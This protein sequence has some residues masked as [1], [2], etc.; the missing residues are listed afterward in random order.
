MNEFKAELSKEES[1]RLLHE[2]VIPDS[3]LDALA[4]HEKPRAIVLAGQPGAGKGMLVG[5]ARREFNGDIL[6]IDPDELRDAIPGIRQLQEADPI[7]WPDATNRGA[8]NLASGLRDEGIKRHVNLVIDG[9]MSDAG[10]SARTIEALQKKGY[11]V[12][13]RAISSHWLES[14]LGIDQRFTGQ[15]DRIGVARD[16][17]MSFHND[18]YNGLPGNLDKVAERTGVQVRIYDRDLNELYDSRRDV[19][20][21]SEVLRE[22]RAGRVEEPEVRKQLQE[23]WKR[24]QGWHEAMPETLHARQDI[25]PTTAEALIVGSAERAK[26]ARATV[27]AESIVAIDAPAQAAEPLLPRLS[28]VGTTAGLAG[29]GLAAAAYD[30]KETGERVSTAYA[31]DNPSAVRSEATHFTA[32]GVGGAAA[33]FTPAAVGASGGPAAA[34]AVA[35]GYLLTEAFD[36]GAKFLDVRK[37]THQTASDGADYEFNG[38]QWIREDLRADFHDDGVQRLQQQDF[39]APPEIERELNAKASAEAVKQAIGTTN[40]RDPFEQPANPTDAPSTRPSPWRYEAQS[41]EWARAR[42]EEIDPTDPRLPDREVREVATAERAAELNRQALGVIDRNIVEGP[43]VLAAQYQIGAKRSGFGD[44][45][46]E[47]EAV[48]TALNPNTL[49]ASNGKQYVRDAQGQWSHDGTPATGNRAL[50]LDATR[51]RLTPVLAQHQQ[52]LADTKSYEAPTP[53]Q[54]DRAQLRLAYTNEGWNPS[55][56]QFKASYFGAAGGGVWKTTDAGH[57]WVSVFDAQAASVGAVAVAPSDPN[58]IYVGSGQPQPRYDTAAG[59]GVYASRDGGKH[60]AHVGLE[61]TRHIGA[62][63]IDPRD[64]NTL[65]VAALGPL[66][67]ESPERGVFRSTD[68]GQHWT[69]TL[70]IDDATGAVDLASDPARPQV[71]YAA[72]WTARN[73]PWMSYFTPMVGDAGGLFKSID[74]GVSWT[75]IEGGGWPQG[76]LGRVGIAATSFKGKTRLYAVVDH[77]EK[78]GLYRSDDGGATWQTMQASPSL[79][80]RYFAR[81]TVHPTDPDTVY[82]MGRSI[83]VSHDGG[84]TLTIMRGSPGGD[85]YHDLWLNPQHPERMIAASDQG[86]IVTPNGGDSWSDWYNQ[87]T[88]QFYCL[89]NDNRFP[90][91]LYAGQQ[92]NGS[93]SITSRSNFGAISFRDWTPAG[94][95]ERD[96]VVPDPDDANVLYGSGLG[97]RVSRY[98]ARTGD[99]QN[100]TPVQ[101]NTYGRDPRT[102]EH[103]WSWITPLTMAT[104][105]ATPGAAPA[106]YLGSEVLFR[107]DDRGASW[108]VISP[109]LT[110][111]TRD[112]DACK[113]DVAEA[114]ARACGFGTIFSIAPSPHDADE[115]W[116]GTDSGL[117][118]RTRDGGKTW[119]NL[120]P[121]QLPAWSTVARIELSALDREHVYVAVDQHRRDVFAPLLLRTRDGGETW[122]TISAGLPQD[123]FTAVIRA[124]HRRAGLLF[125][126][127]DHG[128]YVSLDDGDRW[129]PFKQGMPTAWVRDMRIVG[130][131]IAIATQGRGLWILDGIS[132]LRELAA[133]ANDSA[134]RLF[135]VADAL[136]LRKNQNKDTPLAAEIPLGENPPT[137][138]LIEYVLP[139]DAKRVALRIVDA[140]GTVVRRFASDDAMTPLPAEQYFSDLY[141]KPQTALPR[142]AGTHRWVWNLRHERPLAT[143]YEY[144]IAATAGI[145]TEALPEGALALPGEYRVELDVDGKRLA[146]PLR[147][148]LDPRLSIGDAELRDILAFNLDL[149]ATLKTLVERTGAAERERATLAKQPASDA[150]TQ[151]EAQLKTL[152]EGP[153]PRGLNAWAE[154]LA[155]VAVDAE[156]AERAPT[157]AQR[158]MLAEAKVALMPKH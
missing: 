142:T 22:A 40:P 84:K 78:G 45:G 63:L 16:V 43:A 128:V 82:V 20:S 148:R 110:G 17:K 127:T 44:F 54:R 153:S 95:D 69:R 109:D 145:E 39:A 68:G 129:R 149:A 49:E 114:N 6:V 38:K 71:I 3:G 86:A 103:R 102:I 104:V 37:I 157:D 101:V 70:S 108:K 4:I 89:H 62:I 98:D 52:Q 133:K 28:R 13:V 152:L 112:S 115:V 25:S 136:R 154:I 83:K 107:S 81:V 124:D 53:E 21:S 105:R 29:L 36:R 73:Y 93:V 7:D 132:R 80:T 139:R 120:T 151:R 143:A 33:M 74:G 11:E 131:D 12:E 26:L 41:G 30:A 67:A 137:G 64:A 65:L 23:G 140:S 56:E 9:S 19:G 10:N 61:K 100:I 118:Q 155:A 18:V 90:Y 106:L 121:A 50:E 92:D 96:C 144:S 91:R 59:D 31:Q 146:S 135:A 126:G 5:A 141:R 87:P 8:F 130:D 2:V 76:E 138:A 113:G 158:N 24:Q 72:A 85:D 57:N 116:V 60:W 47:P 32:R 99:V 123:E 1:R 75:R 46:A 134:P 150:R 88:G 15:I 77:R 66:Y 156:S 55:P 51:E 97:G 35:D 58:V 119:Q 111:R 48:T 117:V 122:D 34:L 94:A 79:T 14:E 125:A 147:I 42:F 27:R